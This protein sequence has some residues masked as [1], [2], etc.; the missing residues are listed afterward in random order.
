MMSLL[1]HAASTFASRWSDET[2]KMRAPL[3]SIDKAGRPLGHVA[4]KYPPNLDTAIIRAEL[5]RTGAHPIVLLAETR[6]FTITAG[7]CD[8]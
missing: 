1:P 3:V 7:G 4:P 5:L 2:V 6:V 8:A